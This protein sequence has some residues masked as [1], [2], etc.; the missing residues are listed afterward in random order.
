MLST[1]QQTTLHA[2][3]DRLIPPDDYP[4]A[5]DAGVGDYL[6]RQ[7]QR[8]L[9]AEEETYRLGLDALEAEA[10][11]SAHGSFAALP[12]AEQDA[13]LRRVEAGQVVH[14]WPLDPASFFQSVV[15][16][17]AEGY[18]A[19]PGN[20]GNRNEQAWRMIGFVPGTPSGARP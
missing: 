10:L 3:M 9:R 12:P 18:Y 8:D 14:A 1:A 2:L 13:L 16:H 6:A 11:A 15:Q 7:F 20:G 4:G 19:N 5:W 17:V